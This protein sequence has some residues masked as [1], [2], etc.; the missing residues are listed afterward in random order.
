[1]WSTTFI[2]FCGVQ[3]LDAHKKALLGSTLIFTGNF[4]S[5]F[6]ILKKYK[7]TFVKV[8]KKYML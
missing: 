5:I 6:I 4:A 2:G 1:M 3:V 8:N 7:L